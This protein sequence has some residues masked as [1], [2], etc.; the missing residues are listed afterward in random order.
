MALIG[1]YIERCYPYVISAIISAIL[2]H[3]KID[4]RMDVNYT[5]LLNGLVNLESIVIGFIGAIMPVVLSMRNESKFVR[6]IFE[7]DKKGL[8]GKYVK[9]TIFVGLV[10]TSVS[11]MMHVRNSMS[12]RISSFIYYFWIF[13][14][15]LFLFS[16]YGSMS[17]MVDLI[18]SKDIT[19]EKDLD[20][21]GISSTHAEIEIKEE[22]KN[23]NL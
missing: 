14:T 3:L 21:K 13:T 12:V 18:F 1:Y 15:L 22:F 16:T 6:Y 9:S 2:F 10:G 17:H 23:P 8:F 20:Q 11:L 4:I 19:D 5:E 7:K